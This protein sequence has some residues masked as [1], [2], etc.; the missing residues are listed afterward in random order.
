MTDSEISIEAKILAVADAFDA[1]TTNR[2]YNRVKSAIEAA[3]ELCGLNS[4]YDAHV[5]RVLKRL[6]ADGKTSIAETDAIQ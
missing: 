2:G 1:M 3:D 5:T 6:V 4:Q